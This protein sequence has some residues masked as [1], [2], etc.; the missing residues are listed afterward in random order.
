ML[1]L[2][3]PPLLSDGGTSD[4]SATHAHDNENDAERLAKALACAAKLSGES[5]ASMWEIGG[6]HSHTLTMCVRL[7]KS[8][9]HSQSDRAHARTVQLRRR[10]AMALNEDALARVQGL[11]S[12]PEPTAR[13]FVSGSARTQAWRMSAGREP[14]SSRAQRHSTSGQT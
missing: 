4:P 1:P 10:I 14:T 8:G 7:R 12:K 2:P 3:R 13:V 5:A 11:V 6:F 9:E